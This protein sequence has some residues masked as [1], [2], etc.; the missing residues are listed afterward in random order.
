[1]DGDSKN[2]DDK[3]LHKAEGACSH[4][5]ASSIVPVVRYLDAKPNLPVSPYKK[6]WCDFETESIS[7]LMTE[8]SFR[9]THKCAAIIWGFTFMKIVTQASWIHRPWKSYKMLTSNPQ[10]FLCSFPMGTWFQCCDKR[11][12]KKLRHLDCLWWCP[13]WPYGC[14]K[15]VLW[16][17][18]CKEFEL[19]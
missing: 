16:P 12:W 13:F 18:S 11:V 17:R 4:A 7:Y 2:C 10:K 15:S 5:L 8:Q 1:M 3:T 19:L 9:A 14:H 6:R